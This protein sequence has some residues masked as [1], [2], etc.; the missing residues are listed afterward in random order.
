MTG[1]IVFWGVLAAIFAAGDLWT[2]A[3]RLWPYAL[4]AAASAGLAT[5][6][7][8]VGLQWAAYALSA[9][10]LPFLVGRWS[11]G[12]ASGDRRR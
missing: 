6:G 3:L 9:A 2:R 10:L 1:W 7:A 8:P 5:M 12:G 11:S 4:A